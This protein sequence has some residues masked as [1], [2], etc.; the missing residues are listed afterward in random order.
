MLICIAYEYGAEYSPDQ[1]DYGRFAR[2]RL[3]RWKE[4]V[5]EVESEV[6]YDMGVE[7]EWREEWK[8]GPMLG[9]YLGRG[10]RGC[11]MRME[12]RI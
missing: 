7:M 5:G 10:W 6:E 8:R 11:W 3:A 12:M 1:T 4:E 2:A 9:D